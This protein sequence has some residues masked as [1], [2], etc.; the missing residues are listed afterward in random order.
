MAAMEP[1]VYQWMYSVLSADTTIQ[2]TFGTRIYRKLIPQTIA[3]NNTLVMQYMGGATL[4]VTN[5][6]RIWSDML[7]LLKAVGTGGNYAA[8]RD[9]MARA[10][11]LLDRVTGS[12]SGASI[13]WSQHENEV[14]IEA[15][16]EG[17]VTYESIAIMYRVKAH[18]V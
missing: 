10:D 3:Y 9:G 15:I 12:V 4:T 14:P 8:L 1:S 13:V 5:G 6:I 17:G 16:V 18:N 7:F 2:A 11:T